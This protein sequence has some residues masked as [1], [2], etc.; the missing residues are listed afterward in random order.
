MKYLY[1]FSLF[2]F[3]LSCVSNEG[4]DKE[5]ADTL[6]EV[7]LISS[8]VE[9]EQDDWWC[10]GRHF[11]FEF[12]FKNHSNNKIKLHS[13]FV[14]NF[15]TSNKNKPDIRLFL[16]EK[17]LEKYTYSLENIDLG[18]VPLEVTNLFKDSFLLAGETMR[19]RVSDNTWSSANDSVIQDRLE[20]LKINATECVFNNLFKG[21][22]D[23]LE[24]YFVQK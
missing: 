23:D 21:Q 7:K 15:C 24:F 22:T 19:I 14:E 6:I 16:K 1:M 12:E 4:K 2:L 18:Y 8:E 10:S 20:F 17:M 3:L 5:L 13:S 11:Y 9:K